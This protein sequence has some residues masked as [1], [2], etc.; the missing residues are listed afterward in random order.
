MKKEPRYSFLLCALLF[1]LS[2]CSCGRSANDTTASS[3]FSFTTKDVV[4]AEREIAG[5]FGAYHEGFIFCDGG[6]L[7]YMAFED[8]KTHVVCA[9]P[10]CLHKDS[11]C[12]AWLGSS[13]LGGYAAFVNGQYYFISYDEETGYLDLNKMSPEA[14]DRQKVC[15]FN[16]NDYTRGETVYNINSVAYIKNDIAVI[17]CEAGTPEETESE[18][19]F[20]YSIDW[21]PSCVVADLRSG[22]VTDQLDG[23]SVYAVYPDCVWLEKE[24]AETEKLTQEEYAALEDSPYPSYLDYLAWYYQNTETFRETSVYFL[25]TGEL[26]PVHAIPN[27]PRIDESGLVQFDIESVDLGVFNGKVYCET[28]KGTGYEI[29][30]I[31]IETGTH[32]LVYTIENGSPLITN[33][34]DYDSIMDNGKILF[35][36]YEQEYG[37]GNGIVCTLDLETGEVR[38][39]YTDVWNV[40]YRMAGETDDSFIINPGDGKLYRILK[41]DYYNGDFSSM[42]GYRLRFS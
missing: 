40:K 11:N 31:D 21:K 23:Y 14:R 33:M 15:S 12:S 7:K 9:V 36:R 8:G 29:F 5:G 34:T 41:T 22:R 24:T 10:N 42:K 19:G 4:T 37:T 20:T 32:S 17:S 16:Y 27:L 13:Y 3:G 2:L 25:D 39:I 6:L 38:E 30:G 35:V 18:A 28:A 1:I 26:V